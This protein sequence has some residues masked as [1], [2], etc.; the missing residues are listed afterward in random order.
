MILG[1]FDPPD[2]VCFSVFRLVSA[3]EIACFI[4]GFGFEDPCFGLFLD[5]FI[6]WSV[7]ARA[8]VTP[9]VTPNVYRWHSTLAPCQLT[10]LRH[11]FYSRRVEFFK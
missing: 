7:S 6:W 8:S 4:G 10:F 1:G 9:H 11:G 2:L 3:P 5:P